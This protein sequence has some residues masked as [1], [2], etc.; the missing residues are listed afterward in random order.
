M[1]STSN[2]PIVSYGCPL[3]P[4]NLFVSLLFV[5]CSFGSF[6]CLPGH[7]I[8][9]SLQTT[10]VF[11]SSAC[12][13]IPIGVF[14]IVQPDPCLLPSSGPKR[15]DVVDGRW[16]YIH[17]GVALHDLLSDEMSKV[18]GETVDLSQLMYSRI[19]DDED[20]WA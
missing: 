7:K 19:L 1:S 8:F 15:Y 6:L 14:C 13:Y 18:L 11:H 3:L 9:L 12:I 10:T 5:K 4:G 17:D 20:T 16:V 2:H